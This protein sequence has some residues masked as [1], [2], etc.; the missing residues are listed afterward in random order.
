MKDIHNNNPHI[1]KENSIEHAVEMN[2]PIGH[3]ILEELR[4]REEDELKQFQSKIK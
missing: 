2:I 3:Q 4:K 1:I